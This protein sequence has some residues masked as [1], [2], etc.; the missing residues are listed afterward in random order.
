VLAI[1]AAAHVQSGCPPRADVKYEIEYYT[2]ATQAWKPLVQDW[3]I[4]RQGEE[5]RDFW[6][7]SMCWGSIALEGKEV[8]KVLV[9]FRN[10]G[11]K[12]Y[13]RA[14]V[15]VVYRIAKEDATKVT[16]DWTDDS[17]AHRASHVFA[18][19]KPATWNCATGKNV[20]TRWVEFEAASK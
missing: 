19:A 10:S 14:E 16:F 15:H 9:R 3:T 1:H 7:Q 17:G 8:S 4:P 5:P 12:N 2:D 18:A 20:R 13:A 6:S 11:G